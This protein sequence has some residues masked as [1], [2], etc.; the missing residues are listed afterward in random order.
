MP[1]GELKQEPYAA[2]LCFPKPDPAE[3]EN[4]IAELRGLGVDSLEFV[5]NSNVYRRGVPVLGKG[6][7]GIVVAA[8]R[9]G[10][11]VAVKNRRLDADRADL[12]HEA[13]MLRLANT[14]DVGPRFVAASKNF[15]VMELIDGDILP[16][17]LKTH[18]Q[19]AEVQTVLAAVLEQCYRLDERG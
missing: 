9:G 3:L 8:Y 14:A 12:L 1:I 4:R 17:W 10:Q 7:V 15:L 11:R 18:K 13:K 6:F 2:I 5:G 19:K 16:N